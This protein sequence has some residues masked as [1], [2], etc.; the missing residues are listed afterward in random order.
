MSSEL[1]ERPGG[2]GVNTRFLDSPVLGVQGPC[3]PHLPS[4]RQPKMPLHIS[5]T[6]YKA[7]LLS[8][9]TTDRNLQTQG[10]SG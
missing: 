7:T 8:M 3:P 4:L 1:F 6:F 10:N 5:G 9:S 2:C